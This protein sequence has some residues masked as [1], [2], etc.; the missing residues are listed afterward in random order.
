[1]STIV[2]DLA[3]LNNKNQELKVELY[4]VEASLGHGI[5]D[6]P[7]V[8]VDEE[9]KSE[10]FL[11]QNDLDRKNEALDLLHEIQKK[12]YDSEAE[13]AKEKKTVFE[14]EKKLESLLVDLGTNLYNNYD[15]NLASTF[16]IHY[17][18]AN[19]EIKE[20]EDLNAQ[21]EILKQP[22]NN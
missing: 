7:N 6:N 13:I 22:E 4:E 14:S 18:E 9:L 15:S 2:E 5:V 3:E 21:K 12:I 19:Q 11:I 17:A 1:M 20:I 8:S 10:Y 16:G